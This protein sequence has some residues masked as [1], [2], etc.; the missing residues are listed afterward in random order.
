MMHFFIVS[1]A[2][3]NPLQNSTEGER[4]PY[5]RICY[6]HADKNPFQKRCI[7]ASYI[8]NIHA[9]RFSTNRDSTFFFRRR[10]R[11]SALAICIT[12]SK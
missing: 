3:I 1:F 2:P 5:I 6:L 10:L 11:M 12:A 9:V 7:H 8:D 4:L